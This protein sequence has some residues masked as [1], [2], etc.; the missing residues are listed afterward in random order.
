MLTSETTERSFIK[1]WNRKRW[2]VLIRDTEKGEVED[3]LKTS[4]LLSEFY[5]ICVAHN[6]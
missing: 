6:P 1:I 2:R 5:F 3:I 4:V